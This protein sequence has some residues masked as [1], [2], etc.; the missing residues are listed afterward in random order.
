MF[1]FTRVLILKF[2]HGAAVLQLIENLAEII[3]H[4]RIQGLSTDIG[5]SVADV[6]K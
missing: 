6:R 2:R 5:A 4:R 1:E 3:S